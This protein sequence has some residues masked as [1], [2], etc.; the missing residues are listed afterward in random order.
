[1][2]QTDKSI[3]AYGILKRIAPSVLVFAFA[4]QM[5]LTGCATVGQKDESI[6]DILAKENDLIAKVKVERAIPAVKQ[7]ISQSE[8]LQTSEAHLG[9]AL[10]EIESAN[11]VIMTTLVNEEKQ[12][13]NLERHA[14]HDRE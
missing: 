6:E 11:Q 13:V 4:L 3:S 10:E 14:G 8:A 12:E 7:G 5:V 1:M 9:V 2:N